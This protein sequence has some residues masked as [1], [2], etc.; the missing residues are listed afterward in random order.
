MSRR[1]F[2]YGTF[3]S[4]LDAPHPRSKAITENLNLERMGRMAGRLYDFGAWPGAIHERQD[5]NF[6]VGQIWNGEHLT[7]DE[8]DQLARRL[9]AIEGHPRLF[10][11]TEV[12]LLDGTEVITYLYNNRVSR[13][14]PIESGDW[15]DAA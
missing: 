2:V 10:K 3:R 15:E 12:V 9:D 5:K 13:A 8:W 4:D 6:V 1:V 11:R 7:D 14:D